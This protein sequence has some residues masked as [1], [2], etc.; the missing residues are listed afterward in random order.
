MAVHWFLYA[1]AAQAAA[2]PYC[3]GDGAFLNIPTRHPSW[4]LL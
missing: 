3:G 2:N 1:G 4:T